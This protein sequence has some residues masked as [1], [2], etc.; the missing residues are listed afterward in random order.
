MTTIRHTLRI[1]LV[2]LILMAGL[3]Q[4]PPKT[5]VRNNRGDL[6]DAIQLMRTMVEN[7]QHTCARQLAMDL[8]LTISTLR[9]LAELSPRLQSPS[10]KPRFDTSTFSQTSFLIPQIYNPNINCFFT[11]I[12]DTQTPHLCIY[13]SPEPPPPRTAPVLFMYPPIHYI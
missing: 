9:V 1:I 5:L 7:A 12:C 4:Y 8:N 10:D 6:S 3:P 2:V 11:F 13:L